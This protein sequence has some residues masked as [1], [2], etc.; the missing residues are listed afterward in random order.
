MKQVSTCKLFYTN[1]K[2]SEPNFFLHSGLVLRPEM[3]F[4]ISP[5]SCYTSY[6]L[7]TNFTFCNILNMLQYVS[8]LS[9]VVVFYTFLIVKKGYACNPFYILL[10]TA[11]RS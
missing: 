3:V 10:Q 2:V 7:V 1:G 4:Y 11:L 8:V 9:C 6:N 5:E